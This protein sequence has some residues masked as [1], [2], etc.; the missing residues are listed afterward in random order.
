MITGIIT[1][2]ILKFGEVDECGHMQ[3][4]CRSLLHYFLNRNPPLRK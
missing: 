2:N 4:S 1:F 3:G